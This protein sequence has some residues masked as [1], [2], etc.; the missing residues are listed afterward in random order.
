M[1]DRLII[2]PDWTGD[3]SAV[4]ERLAKLLVIPFPHSL[5]MQRRHPGTTTRTR[6]IELLAE[7]HPHYLTYEE[8][9]LLIAGGITSARVR[10]IA[11]ELEAEGVARIERHQHYRANG[12]G[13]GADAV[14]HHQP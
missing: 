8:L 5:P 1:T 13:P 7:W 4:P 9:A 12:K 10:Q 11:R 3:A 2:C 14:Y 6:V